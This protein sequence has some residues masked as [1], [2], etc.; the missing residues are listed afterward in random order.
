MK[1]SLFLES[2]T[3][4]SYSTVHTC[5]LLLHLHFQQWI[6]FQPWITLKPAF[7]LLR[8]APISRSCTSFTIWFPVK[9]YDD[10]NFLF[11]N[12]SPYSLV[13]SEWNFSCAFNL[14]SRLR[15]PEGQLENIMRNLCLISIIKNSFLKLKEKRKS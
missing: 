6:T 10:F 2:K 8:N 12:N 3:L 13:F 11:K 1:Y 15:R 14:L 5:I 9:M 4:L 7:W